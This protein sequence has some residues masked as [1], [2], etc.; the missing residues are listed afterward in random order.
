MT[1]QTEDKQVETVEEPVVEKKTA[2]KAKVDLELRERIA[3]MEKA[4]RE[5]A[6]KDVPKA[7]PK[8]VAEGIAFKIW[9]MEISKALNLRPY[10]KEIILADFK[11]RGLGE[12]EPKE[13]Y[14]HALELFGYKL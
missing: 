2:A 11:A 10:M 14:M 4:K 12:K 5:R 6:L 7:P 9:W 8:K 3:R 13:K 1:E